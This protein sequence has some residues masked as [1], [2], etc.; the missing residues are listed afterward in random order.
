MGRGAGDDAVRGGGGGIEDGVEL[1]VA[2]G[3]RAGEAL[4]PGEG[5]SG[6]DF[7]GV[8]LWW[9]ANVDA[10]DVIADAKGGSLEQGNG[11]GGGGETVEEGVNAVGVVVED[12]GE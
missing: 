9:G 3:G 11:G 5:A 7:N 10:G 8:G 12:V 2:V 6:V 4:D 1:V